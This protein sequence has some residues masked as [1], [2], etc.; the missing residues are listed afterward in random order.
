[1]PRKCKHRFV[2]VKPQKT[3]KHLGETKYLFKC[4]KCGKTSWRLKKR[5]WSPYAAGTFEGAG[6]L[7]RRRPRRP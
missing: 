3:H 1:M 5:P 6:Y 4:K 7:R 2:K